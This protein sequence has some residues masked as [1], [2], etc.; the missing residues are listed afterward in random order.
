MLSVEELP[1]PTVSAA[2]GGKNPLI[3][4]WLSME[5]RSNPTEADFRG[6]MTHNVRQMAE[7][8][9]T[10][11]ECHVDQEEK[12]HELSR[13]MVVMDTSVKT[14]TEK[15]DAHT[16]ATSEMLT[17]YRFTRRLRRL[18]LGVAAS[19]AALLTFA[20]TAV[21]FIGRIQK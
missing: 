8:I 2:D 12:I 9:E 7:Q 20:H 10:L 6:L 4:P 18:M 19:I 13:Q 17:A 11:R 3:P 16:N 14:L 5:R 21:E 1:L 15:I